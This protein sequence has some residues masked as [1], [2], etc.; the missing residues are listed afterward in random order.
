[1]LA[2]GLKPAVALAIRPSAREMAA[3]R[4]W[5][6]AMQ[7]RGSPAPPFSFVYGGHDSGEL[8]PEWQVERAVRRIGRGRTQHTITW[9]DPATGLLVRCVAVVYSRFPTVEW[10]LY[11]KNDGPL[12]S[13]IV[14]NVQALDVRIERDADAEFLLHHNV[15]SRTTRRD[16]APLETPLPPGTTKRV[17]AAGGRPT[18][19]D[20]S[21]FNLARGRAGMIVAVGWPGQWA[22]EFR[23]DEARGLR[24]RAGQELTRLTLHP[25]EEIRTPLMVLQEWSGD[26]M[27][28]QNLWRRWMT[29]HNLP[30]PGGTLPPPYLL[31]TSSR[32]YYVMEG[33]TEANQIAYI[34][35]YLEEGLAIDYW[36]MDAGWYV[37]Q[38][39]WVQTGTW[40]I[41]PTRFPNGLRPIAD[42][43]HARGVKTLLWLE[44]E[45]V[46]AGTWLADVH[47]EWVLGGT[48]GGLLDLGNP[49]A[50]NWLVDHVDRLLSDNRIDVYRQDF[51]IDPLRFWR[52]NDAPHRQGITEIRHVMAYLAFWDELRRRH[53][54]LL[55]DACA[56][57]GRRNDLETM[58]RALPLWRSDWA[59]DPLGSQGMTYGLSMWLP[60][61][62]TGTVAE[63]NAPF[64]GDGWTPVEPY[65]FWS[66]AA[67]SLVLS[68]DVG[69]ALDYAMLRTLVR[70][71]R[72]ASRFYSGDYY[73]LT[74]Y[75]LE[76]TDWIAWQF[77]RPERKAGLVQ[78]FRRAVCPD[79][80]RQ[81]RLHGLNPQKRYRVRALNG[82]W[83][84]RMTGR[85]LMERGLPVTIGER[86]GVA[87][88]V[89][90]AEP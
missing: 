70:Q 45:R 51:N 8:L 5:I 56:S 88:L 73:P 37:Q 36:W 1:L 21:Y 10:T 77:D 46:A 54:T 27:R 15:G 47:P 2:G 59:Y 24:I 49:D 30:R 62:G 22:I 6:D 78:A 16:Y 7:D 58:R 4:V 28:G 53:P 48:S 87:V 33:A 69:E 89:Y 67:P 50:W 17:S 75:S 71:W 57:G 25:G 86:P 52:A 31:S 90:R 83:R 60:Y 61:Y 19:S 38:D 72:Q 3:S 79:E 26:W 40:E 55:I 11:L 34:D 9:R 84:S 42:H 29:T 66:D 39:G 76:D 68:V 12:D 44:P 20:L 63:A 80:T 18:S 64:F 35:R 14:E 74:S 81:L 23:R 85:E 43:A 65:A 41:D 13:P 32:E 82:V